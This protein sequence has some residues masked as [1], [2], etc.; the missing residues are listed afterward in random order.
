M[1]YLDLKEAFYRTVRQLA[2][3]GVASDALL[4]KACARFG[5]PEGVLYD[6][7]CISTRSAL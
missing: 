6:L 4:A 3:G 1:I 2:I 5:L 7:H